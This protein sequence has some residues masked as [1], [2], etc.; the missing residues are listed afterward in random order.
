MYQR[1]RSCVQ[2]TL[3]LEMA[4]GLFITFEIFG[5]VG[6]FQNLMFLEEPSTSKRSIPSN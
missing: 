5:I 2:K 1:L 4:Q 6:M 3:G